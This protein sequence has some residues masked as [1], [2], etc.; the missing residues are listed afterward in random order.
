MHT[1]FESSERTS[2]FDFDVP[3]DDLPHHG[4]DSAFR[5]PLSSV[6][7]PDLHSLL[8]WSFIN[9]LAIHFGLSV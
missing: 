3:H 5:S 7:A 9:T 8:I 2:L 4:Q 1:D 6:Q